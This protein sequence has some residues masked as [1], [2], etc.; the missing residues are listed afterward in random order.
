MNKDSHLI[1]EAYKQARTQLLNELDLGADVGSFGP[2]IAKGLKERESGGFDAYTYDTLKKALGKNSDEIANLIGPIIHNIL[3][4]NNVFPAKGDEK[5]QINKLQNSLHN[6]MPQ[7]IDE[8]KKDEEMAKKLEGAS[9]LT[10][11]RH[12][13]SA[14]I[15][16][17]FITPFVKVLNSGSEGEEA[18]SEE[19]VKAVVKGTIE[20]ELPEGEATAKESP[21]NIRIANWVLEQIDSVTGASEGEVINDVQRKILSSGG[22]GLEERS[23]VSKVKAVISKLVSDR[24]LERKAGRLIFGD[25][26]FAPNDEGTEFK[27]VEDTIRDITGFGARK[28]MGRE[29]WGQGE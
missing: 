28:T 27:S 7:V 4:P 8:L 17:D 5:T 2:A 13:Y 1:F 29:I 24:I 3:F 25:V 9:G 19:E 6:I 11:T 21:V 20:T 18:P 16:R 26:E 23:I 15:T 14:R 12:K 10:G 22:L